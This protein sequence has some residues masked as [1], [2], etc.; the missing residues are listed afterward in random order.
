MITEYQVKFFP[1][2]SRDTRNHAAVSRETIKADSEFNA[3]AQIRIMIADFTKRLETPYMASVIVSN[4]LPYREFEVFA[5]DATVTAEKLATMAD[6]YLADVMATAD[7][8]ATA[9]AA[10]ADPDADQ[11][12][13]DDSDNPES[14][15][16]ENPFTVWGFANNRTAVDTRKGGNPIPLVIVYRSNNFNPYKPE[17]LDMTPNQ[18]RE[19]AAAIIK[20]ADAA[21]SGTYKFEMKIS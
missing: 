15:A 12:D 16:K 14:D 18:A 3:V 8:T 9:D 7:V 20:A 1:I 13:F 4:S 17:S 6:E 5:A 19:I 10:M 11:A 2:S 21:E